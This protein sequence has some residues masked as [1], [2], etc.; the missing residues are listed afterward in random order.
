MDNKN[1]IT[2]IA[3]TSLLL[4]VVIPDLRS[5]YHFVLPPVLNTLVLL[6]SGKKD[7]KDKNGRRHQE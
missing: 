6:Q 7:N 3:M 4:C 2:T 5:S 1:F